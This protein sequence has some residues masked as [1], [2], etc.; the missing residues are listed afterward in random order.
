[1]PTAKQ[2]FVARMANFQKAL[3]SPELISKA[4]TEVEHNQK[5]RMLRN[6]L[7][8]IGFTIL[9]DF[10]KRRIGEVLREVGNSPVAFSA[11]PTKIQEAATVS[12]LRGIQ[13]RVQTLKTDLEDYK[14]FIQNET[15]NVSSTKNA[16]FQISEYSLGWE[17]SNISTD[18]VR[19]FLGILGV[20]GG[21]NSIQLIS[22]LINT[23]I[24][25]PSEIFRNAAQRRHKAAHNA[26]A[27]SL[28][29]DLS[30]FASD[31][32]VIALSYDLLISRC[33]HSIMTND[34]GYLTGAV[35]TIPGHLKFRFLVEDTKN[36]KEYTQGSNRAY[37]VSKDY[38]TLFPDVLMRARAKKENLIIKSVGNKVM[39]WEIP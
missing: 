14:L 27:D 3:L 20:E 33:L 13:S 29:S 38:N 17:R 10:L 11:L 34:A 18:D 12:A 30:G 15:L 7:A 5:A 9:E 24:V 19:D 35:K 32:V 2:N 16:T 36:W 21:W 22:G 23:T 25:T 39:N 26:D 31:A 28:L 37:R 1:M 8:I 4:L 6:G